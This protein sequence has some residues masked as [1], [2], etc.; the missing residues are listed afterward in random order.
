MSSGLLYVT[1]AGELPMTKVR[2]AQQNLVVARNA[3]K[4]GALTA[5][6]VLQESLRKRETAMKDDFAAHHEMCMQ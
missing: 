2:A 5:V 6:Q 1:K 4:A 3:G